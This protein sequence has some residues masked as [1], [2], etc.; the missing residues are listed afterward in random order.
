MSTE[1]TCNL[2]LMQSLDDRQQAHY[3]IFIFLWLACTCVGQTVGH[4]LLIV[5]QHW[6][7]NS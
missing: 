6:R 7:S 5:S 3:Y 2:Q 4:S 1:D